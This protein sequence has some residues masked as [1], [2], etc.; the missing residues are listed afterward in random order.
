[1]NLVNTSA[2]NYVD[3]IK[4]KAKTDLTNQILEDSG[5]YLKGSQLMELNKTLNKCFE[6]YE[7]FVQRDTD[8]HKDWAE[9][10]QRILDTFLSNKKL[11]GLSKNTLN[12]YKLVLSNYLN[13]VGMHLADVS[14]QDLRNYLTYYQSIN[15]ASNT[16]VDNT[17]RILNV[18]FNT[19]NNEG[20]I[21]TNPMCRIKHIKSERNSKKHLLIMKLK[22]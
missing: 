20:F 17:R 22:K 10:N 19:I 3:E 2:Y 5:R 6:K 7:V 1:M 18:F 11:E 8:L 9:D 21:P 15:N 12:Y 14:T 13:V 16:S 4:F